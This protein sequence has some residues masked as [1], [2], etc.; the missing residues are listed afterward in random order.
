M[1]ILNKNLKTLNIFVLFSI[2]LLVRLIFIYFQ[3]PDITKL[4]EDEL[5]YWN[6]SIDYFNKGFI[7]E[8]ILLERMHGIFLYKNT[9]TFKFYK[10]K[11]LFDFT[12]YN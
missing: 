11:N 1:F 10:Y 4:I 7:E 6:S 5:L 9:F 12:I 3:S 2:A 8:S